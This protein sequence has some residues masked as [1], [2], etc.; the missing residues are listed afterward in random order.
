MKYNH[1]SLSGVTAEP[2]SLTTYRI[3]ENGSEIGLVMK[4]LIENS[5][6]WEL[7][8]KYITWE[9]IQEINETKNIKQYYIDK[10]SEI[11][12]GKAGCTDEFRNQVPYKEQAKKMIALAQ[13]LVIANY[14]N[15]LV[16]YDPDKTR[17]CSIKWDLAEK[18]IIFC[19]F[20][21]PNNENKKIKSDSYSFTSF[22]PV[23]VNKEIAQAAY[24]TNKDIFDTLLKIQE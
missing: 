17:L 3:T 20:I 11:I 21:H 8:K 6:D 1:K 18:K 4:H 22:E 5:E 16:K 10:D 23:F 9:E 19:E 14:Y 2:N 13:T 24:S 7:D 12:G 15:S